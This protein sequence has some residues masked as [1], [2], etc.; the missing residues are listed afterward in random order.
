[1]DSLWKKPTKKQRKKLIK[2][3]LKKDKAILKKFGGR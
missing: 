2:D 3:Y 1:M